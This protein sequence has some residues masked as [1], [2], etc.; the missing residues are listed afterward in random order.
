[1]HSSPRR[2]LQVFVLRT[3]YLVSLGQS[4]DVPL[5]PRYP[6]VEAH[7]DWFKRSVGEDLQVDL[8]KSLGVGDEVDANEKPAELSPGGLSV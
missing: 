4:V 5:D 2:G 3:R 7:P 8:L 6:G 1:V